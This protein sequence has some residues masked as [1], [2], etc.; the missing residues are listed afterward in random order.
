[1]L[2]TCFLILFPCVS[3]SLHFSM[4]SI[5]M[6]FFEFLMLA[7]SLFLFLPL[8]LC[9]FVFL[10]VESRCICLSLSG[11]F[12]PLCPLTQT[13]LASHLLFLQHPAYPKMS[14]KQCSQRKSNFLRSQSP[15][16]AKLG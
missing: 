2:K 10:G 9:L 4:V 6:F 14:L 13:L 12:L 11:F 8:H 16:E 1:M 15:P 7:G 3:V 5:F